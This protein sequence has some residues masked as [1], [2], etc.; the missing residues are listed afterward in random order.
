ML[1]LSDKAIDALSA[2]AVERLFDAV[3]DA[4]IARGADEETAEMCSE[5]AIELG[6]FYGIFGRSSIIGIATL[7]GTYDAEFD[8][9]PSV[10]AAL[11]NKLLHPE[12][13]VA[14]ILES[15]A[16]LE[17]IRARAATGSGPGVDRRLRAAG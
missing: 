16:L 5:R 17:R 2:D 9:V 12:Q 15:P 8:T 13:R 6:A 14:R 10:Q 7:L 3:A 1:T 11:T 4:V